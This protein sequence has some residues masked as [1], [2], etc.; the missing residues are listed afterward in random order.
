[1]NL[2]SLIRERISERNSHNQTWQKQMK[3]HL[4][5]VAAICLPIVVFQTQ[6]AVLY[7]DVNSTNPVSPYAGWSTAATNIQDAIDASSSGDQIW[8]TNGIYQTGGK[9]MA[10]DLT[11]RVAL[12]KAVTVQSVNGPW[13]TAIQ[14]A[15]ATNGPAAVR[16]A[17]LTNN[18]A[19]IGFTLQWGA[20]RTSGDSYALESGGGV[21]CVSSNAIVA[22]C[23]IISNTAYYY[24]GGGFQGTLNNC[25][26][27][28]NAVSGPLYWAA[29]YWANL[30]NC[31]VVSNNCSGTSGCQ[32]TNCIA[33]Y[34][35]YA[36]Y[37]G[38]TL[39][40]CC[41]IPLPGGDG[42]FTDA[43]QL[44]VDGVHISSASPCIGAGTNVTTGTDI[45][46]NAWAAPPS[47]GCVEG[48]SAPFVTKPQVRL[49]RAPVGFTIGNV[50]LAGQAPFTFQWLKD[51]APLQD[52]GHFS[53][54]QTTNLVATGVSLA[55][56]GSY[57]LVVSNALGVVTSQVAQVVVHVVDAAGVNPIPPFS[58][59]ATA[60][61]NIQ[62]AIDLATA[63]DI[64]LVTNGVYATGG[65]VMARSPTNRVVL[66]KAVTVK[67]VNGP[68]VTIIQGAWDPVSTN[69]PAAVRCAYLTNGAV[70][71]GFTLENGATPGGG[72]GGD[73]SDS[74]GGVFCD[75]TNTVVS[76][77]VLT[78]NSSIFGGGICQGTLNNS[79]V[80]GNLASYGG[81]AYSTTLNNCT[82][83]NNYCLTLTGYGGGTYDCVVR[84]SIVVNNFDGFPYLMSIDNYYRDGGGLVQYSYSC[85]YPLPSG[86]GNINGNNASPQF[87]DLFHIATTSPCRGVGSAL[88]ASGTDLDGEPWANPPSM[89]C[90]EVVVSN[91]VGPLSVNLSASQT[92]LL[93]S[94]PNFSPP[95]HDDF[96][97]GNIT[98][99]ATYVT[100]SFGDGPTSTNFGVAS[101]HW[102]TN[103]GDY[104]VTF[105]AYNTDNPA[106]VS[107]NTLI[108]VL[109]PDVPQLQSPALLANGF[110]FQFAGQWNANYT[111]QYTTNLA[112]PVTWQTLQTIFWNSDD[113]IQISDSTPTNAVRFYRVLAQ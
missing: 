11:N 38:G 10:G 54:T 6:A 21:W 71:N 83:V 57:Q 65:K 16:C 15:G 93:V 49:I 40:H 29:A 58:T 3:L 85:T 20:T 70:L 53:F 74:G 12:N 37:N 17:W 66:N 22:N 92:N 61:T 68:W 109:L 113:V 89:G 60:A 44:L 110:Q 14:G 4:I 7:V 96:F 97:Q 104:T 46:G 42:N 63:G 41:T 87:L 19:L 72:Y 111:I 35:P 36:N 64:V 23:V 82:V 95:P 8:V 2:K 47:V 52:N 84:N 27:S 77:C 30:N 106:G 112:P 81:G 75:S 1:M 86:A 33:Y 76:N 28:G 18:A 9:V 67:S 69:G 102:W 48:D 51:G 103:T 43:P 32:L 99:R 50:S 56:A 79:L 91:L 78:N 39:S 107:T 80:I 105:T 98:G 5:L 45:F 55:D 31:T 26:I 108:H 73:I 59:W 88:Y 25:L 90:D 94:T 34:N 24:G 13:V 62:D 100:W 101:S